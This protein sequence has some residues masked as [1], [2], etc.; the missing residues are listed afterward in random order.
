M[1]TPIAVATVEEEVGLVTWGAVIAGG[2]AAAAIS[3]VLLAFGIGVGFSVVSPWANESVS[4][5]TSHV[6]AGIYLVVVA[7]L[8][9]TVGGYLAGRMRGRWAVHRDEVFFRDTARGFLAWAFATVLTAAALG[10]ATTSILSG[11]TAGIAPAAATAGVQAGQSPLIEGYVD[12]LFRAPRDPPTQPQ[13]PAAD[14]QTSRAEVGRIVTR[15]LRRGAEISA[16]DRTHLA[17]VVSARTGMPQVEAEKRV[18]EVMTQAKQA[19]DEARKAAAKLALWLAASMLA[20]A[21]AASLAATAG[22]VYRDER[23]YEPSWRPPRLFDQP[24]QGGSY[25]G[26]LVAFGCSPQP[27][28]LADDPAINETPA[29]SRGFLWYQPY[30][31]ASRWASW[32]TQVS[33]SSLNASSVLSSSLSVALRSSAPSLFPSSSAQVASVP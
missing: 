20:G 14:M 23:W 19:T 28:H 24:S 11:A 8:A 32:L 5:T 4:A 10:T 16:G 15:G 9:S 25:A 26:S 21:F 27:H 30:S 22:G 12:Q 31:A 29:V 2:I 7:M 17:Q 33:A 3:L 6:G 13:Q 18:N 1:A